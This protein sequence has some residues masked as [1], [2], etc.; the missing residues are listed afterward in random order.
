[1]PRIQAVQAAAALVPAKPVSQGERKTSAPRPK[2]NPSPASMPGWVIDIVA[3]STMSRAST[4]SA[5]FCGPS[6]PCQLQLTASSTPAA[7]AAQSCQR[8]LTVMAELLRTGSGAGADCHIP[9]PGPD[10]TAPRPR[11]AAGAHGA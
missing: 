8:P 11:G 5:A 3:A 4:N 1:A 7:M 9:A 10:G 2:M 6:I